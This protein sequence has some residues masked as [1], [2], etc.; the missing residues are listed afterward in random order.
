M[1]DEHKIGIAVGVGW[2]GEPHLQ[3]RPSTPV[4]VGM[5]VGIGVGANPNPH[6][7]SR[8]EANETMH[9]AASSPIGSVS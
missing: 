5:E 6:S 1:N 9:S 4:G 3:S 2:L 8:S 7:H